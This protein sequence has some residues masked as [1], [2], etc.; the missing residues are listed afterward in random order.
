LARIDPSPVVR[1]YLAA[2]LQRLPLSDRWDIADGLVGRAGDAGDH[3]LPLMYWYAVEPLAALD[4]SRAARLASGSKIPRIQEFMARRIGAIGTAESMALLV[5]LLGRAARSTERSSL[6]TGIEESLRGRRQV[7]MPAA[8][9]E[10]Y[11]KLNDDPDR[12]VRS[13]ATALG[14]TFGDAAARETLRLVLAD[15]RAP[16][17][18]RRE[19]LAALLQAKDPALIVTLH[20]LVRD[21]G[22]GG[23]AIRALSAYDDPASSDLLMAA[24]SSL[25]P[26]ERRDALNTLAARKGSAQALLSAV[27]VGK[28][29]RADLTADLVR[30]LRNLKDP[31]LDAQI[32][33][34]WGTV[35]ETTGDRARLIAQFKTML[36]SK[37]SHPPDLAQGRAVFTKVCQQC[38]TLFGVGRQ[39]GPDLTGSNR[40][41][42]DYL[43]S[44]VLDPSALIGK[45]YLANVI[46]MTDG[47]VLTGIIR[48]EDKDTITLMTANETITLPK[49]E[50]E[51]RK[52]SEQSM[53]PDDL[54]KAVSEQEIRSLVSYLA[55]PAQVEVPAA[56]GARKTP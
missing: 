53:M 46:G 22:L 50:V 4:A 16:L 12:Q 55:S 3:N 40:A 33:Q 54:W 47:R 52:A 1:L 11:R 48:A 13:R 6:L 41:D 29:P 19:A 14:V 36:K 42:L 7:A 39:V 30:Q 31:G 21:A 32:A 34:V 5:D 18:P 45:D 28:L 38:H 27:G 26:I 17:A 37:P 44:N 25:G 43:L 49:S 51:Q 23:L 8:W 20:S 35:R 10:V 2:A 24:Y 56:E 15:G 9:P